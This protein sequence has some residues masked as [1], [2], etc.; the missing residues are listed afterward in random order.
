MDI[1]F[2]TTG[3]FS[4][5]AVMK[6]ALRMAP[7]LK[8][9]GVEISIIATETDENRKLTARSRFTRS[10]CIDE[11]SPLRER[12]RKQRIVRKNQPDVLYVCGL[13]VR[14]FVTGGR[15]DLVEHCEI[16]SRVEGIGLIASA[17]YEFLE[18]ASVFSYDGLVLASEY[19]ER[20]FRARLSRMPINKPVIRLPYGCEA[21]QNEVDTGGGG[22]EGEEVVMYLGSIYENYGIYELIRSARQVTQQRHDVSFVILGDGPDREGA[23]RYAEELGLGGEVEFLGF[24]DEEKLDS[25]LSSADVLLAPMRDT[26]QDRARC[27]SKIPL[28]MSHQKPVVTCRVGEADNYLGEAG[29]YY[30]PGDAESMAK[31]TL[32]A[33]RVGRDVE[34]DLEEI[35]WTRLT[36][37]FL[38]W[39]DREFEVR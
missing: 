20:E 15:V 32:R 7:C 37:R 19:L 38:G 21:D 39:L 28:Y 11:A 16:M 5:N 27:P 2:V 29:F 34:Y 1:C 9:R 14:N 33:L 10:F 12:R 31:A 35:S 23:E 8:D 6:R 25:Y 13:G 36:D 4:D 17:K 22:P 18:W 30:E 24:V 26:V 3:T